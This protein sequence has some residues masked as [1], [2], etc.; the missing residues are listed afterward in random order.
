MQ[1]HIAVD[2]IEEIFANKICALLS[3][4][5]LRDLVDVRALEASGL[6]LEDAFQGATQKDAGLTPAM[7]AWVLSSLSIGD[8]AHLP[9]GVTAQELKLYLQTLVERLSKKAFP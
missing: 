8:D 5:E 7:L 4:A 2:S 1:G 3:R 9:Q 6:K